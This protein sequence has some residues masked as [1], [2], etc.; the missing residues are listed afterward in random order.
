MVNSNVTLPL[1]SSLSLADLTATAAFARRLAG[2]VRIGDVLALSGELGV[3]KTTFARSFINALPRP[4]GDY[5]EEEV[6]SP[7]FTLVQ[8][9][10]RRPAAV[11]HVDLYRLTTPEEAVELGLE[12]AFASAITL[13][14][15]PERL[16]PYLL[17][18]RLQLAF[19]FA[20]GSDGRQVDL[21]GGQGWQSRLSG[22]LAHA[23]A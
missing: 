22:V 6:P 21:F 16:G 11:W 5:L 18:D 17:A 2:V 8:I 7:T 10:D 23:G 13:I 4:T 19:R 9:Y 14:E 20:D 1:L 15:W 12:E 3:G